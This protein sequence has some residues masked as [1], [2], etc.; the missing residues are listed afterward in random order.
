MIR[1]IP[2]HLFFAILHFCAIA[3]A[4]DATLPEGQQ[5]EL[6]REKLPKELF[7][8]SG[9]IKIQNNDVEKVVNLWLINER[10]RDPKYVPSFDTL[11]RSRLQVAEVLLRNAAIEQYAREKNLTATK[12]ELDKYIETQKEAMRK[13]GQ[14]Y[15]Q[16]LA[17]MGMTDEEFRRYQTAK[18]PIEQKATDLVTEKEVDAKCDEVKDITPLRRVAHILFQ[19][20]G[21]A[22][23]PKTLERTKDEAR[24]LAEDTLAKAKAGADFAELAKLSED[25]SSRANGGQ[26]D[27]FPLKGKGAMVEEFGKA[28]YAIP[29][30]GD[31][32]PVVETPYGF[33]VIKL[34]ADRTKE[35]RERIKMYEANRKFHELTDPYIKTILDKAVFSDEHTRPDPNKPPF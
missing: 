6:P 18:I 31:F 24:K 10:K 14:T 11:L 23:A 13:T 4:G 29:K 25:E 12:A 27:Y 17:D 34:T 21:S 1:R 33:H 35:F 19:F 2:L 16:M 9:E 28:A 26:Y 20:K 22:G 30:I 32:S 7:A 3:A 8:K 15:E 5:P